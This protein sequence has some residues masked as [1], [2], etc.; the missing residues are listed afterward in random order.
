MTTRKGY[1][2]AELDVV[3]AAHFYDEYMP[4]VVPSL[5]NMVPSSS[6]GATLRSS[7]KVAGT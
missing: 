6:P 7:R 3:D 2:F 5:R 4:R 1:L